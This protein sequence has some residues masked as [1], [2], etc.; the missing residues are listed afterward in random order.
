MLKLLKTCEQSMVNLFNIIFIFYKVFR[1]IFHEHENI[2]V[3]EVNSVTGLYLKTNFPFFSEISLFHDFGNGMHSL[4]IGW[5]SK[6]GDNNQ[7]LKSD[8]VYIFNVVYCIVKV[9]L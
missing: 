1:N 5:P 2:Y 3:N 4:Y 6:R 8:N 7:F 9:I